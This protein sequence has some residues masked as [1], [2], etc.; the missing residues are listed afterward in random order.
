M[1]SLLLDKQLV[2]EVPS[3][4]ARLLDV[5]WREVEVQGGAA[6][7]DLL[8]Q[9]AGHSFVVQ[10]LGR[11]SPGLV[12]MHAELATARVKRLRKKATDELGDRFDI[13]AFH[14]QVLDSGALPLAI[15]EEKIDRWIAAVKDAQPPHHARRGAQIRG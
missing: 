15:L 10:V 12:V 9:A 2:R 7:R 8:V 1:A 4:L 3:A 5:P 6:G 13:R 11:V 14:A